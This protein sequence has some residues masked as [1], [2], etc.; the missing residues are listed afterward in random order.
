[1]AGVRV[2]CLRVEKLKQRGREENERAGDAEPSSKFPGLLRARALN[3][4]TEEWKIGFMPPFGTSR[5]PHYVFENALVNLLTYI[6]RDP[7]HFFRF[8]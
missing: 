6:H 4:P 1:M 3:T 8:I 5:R 2:E 7:P